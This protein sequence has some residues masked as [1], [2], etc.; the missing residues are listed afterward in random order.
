MLGAAWVWT[1]AFPVPPGRWRFLWG[2]WALSAVGVVALGA[3][4]AADAGRRHRPPARDQPRAGAVLARPPDRRGRRCGRRGRGSSGAPSVAPGRWRGPRR[5]ARCWPTSSRGTRRPIPD[6][7]SERTSRCSGSISPRWARGLAGWPRCLP[8]SRPL[9]AR[10]A[11]ARRAGSPPPP[12]SCSGSSLRPG[13]LRAVDE[14]GSVGAPA[15]DRVRAARGSEGVACCS[16]SPRSA[17]SIAIETCREG[18]RASPGCCAFG[19]RRSRLGWSSSGSR[20]YLTGFAPPRYSPEPRRRRPRSWR[21]AMTLRPPYGCASRSPRGPSAW[22]SSPRRSRDYDTGRPV[23]ADRIT[24]TF[25]KPD[26]PDVGTS[27]LDLT[28]TAA[29]HVPGGGHQPLA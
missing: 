24:L 25:S 17:P 12:R 14:V 3:A 22:T 9:G 15:L 6:H 8:G 1:I 21:P 29:G 4:Q 19:P 28:R 20:G 16:S 2:A 23:G 10:T 13:V 11:P 18:R 5:P 27:V 26:R 7:G